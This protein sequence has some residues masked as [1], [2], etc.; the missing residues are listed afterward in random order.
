MRVQLDV[1]DRLLLE[2]ILAAMGGPEPDGTRGFVKIADPDGN[3]V[4]PVRAGP[5][6]SEDATPTTAAIDEVKITDVALSLD[7]SAYAAGDVL[8]ATQVVA[9]CFK[10]NDAAGLLQSLI[11]IDKDDQGVA[12]DVYFLSADVAMGTENAAPS[13]SD[14]NAEHILGV[15]SVAA[16]D[17]KDL[18][19]VRQATIRNIALPVCAAAGTDDLY[20]A[21]VNGSGTPTFTAAGIVLRIGVVG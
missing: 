13:I 11:V 9:A 21:V 4:D 19:G 7:T 17:Y 14:A 10:A 8:A 2:S 1:E 16:A 5:R 18:G 15:V 6:L 3:P 20:V 12:L